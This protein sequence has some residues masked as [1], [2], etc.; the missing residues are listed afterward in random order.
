MFGT[1]F[2]P[3]ANLM[4]LFEIAVTLTLLGASLTRR[5]VHGQYSLS[6]LLLHRV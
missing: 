3:R 5:C 1:L 4:R 6:P 2:I